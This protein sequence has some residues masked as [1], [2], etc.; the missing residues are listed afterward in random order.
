MAAAIRGSWNWL[1][2]AWERQPVLFVSVVM[3]IAGECWLN[4]YRNASH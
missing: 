2:M 1:K 4:A 3:G